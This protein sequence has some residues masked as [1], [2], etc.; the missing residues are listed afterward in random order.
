MTTFTIKSITLPNRVTL[1]YVEQGEPSGVPLV[2]LHGFA[3]SW[4]SFETV[5]PHLPASIHAFALTQRGHGDASR[6]ETGYRFEDFAADLKL[7]M[8][9]LDIPAAVLA[10]HSMGSGVAQRFALDNPARVRGLALMGSFTRLL[11]NPGVQ[12]LWDSGVST[13]ADPVEEG[14]VREFQA[15]T[16]NRPLSPAFFEAIVQESRKLPARVWKAAFEGFLSHDYSRQLT[17]IRIPTL[18]A[19]GDQD[20]FCSRSEQ[21]ALIAAIAGARLVVYADAGHSFHWEEPAR[22]AADLVGF[23]RGLGG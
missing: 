17:A 8:D 22:F 9:A 4:R 18:I 15:S 19:W 12:A 10:G 1:P 3:D 14:L 16:I 23:I 13:L 6:P 11:G 20:A 21:D 7:F 5:L 2:L